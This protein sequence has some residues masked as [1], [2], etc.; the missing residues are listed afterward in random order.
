M[1]TQNITEQEF[2]SRDIKIILRPKKEEITFSQL[3]EKTGRKAGT[4]RNTIMKQYDS[5][6]NYCK[7]GRFSFTFELLN[8]PWSEKIHNK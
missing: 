2:T 1:N 6:F 8:R 7:I 4:V 3:V 5:G